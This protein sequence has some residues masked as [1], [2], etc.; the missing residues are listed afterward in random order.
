MCLDRRRVSTSGFGASESLFWLVST[1]VWNSAVFCQRAVG[2]RHLQTERRCILPVA[3]E[4]CLVSKSM[5]MSRS[6]HL[7]ETCRRRVIRPPALKT[8]CRQFS[9]FL[10]RIRATSF[11]MPKFTS[12]PLAVVPATVRRCPTAPMTS[13][14]STLVLWKAFSNLANQ[15]QRR[16]PSIHVNVFRNRAV[17]KNVVVPAYSHTLS[18]SLAQSQFYPANDCIGGCNAS[19][20]CMDTGFEDEQ[21]YCVLATRKRESVHRQR[22]IEQANSGMCVC[23]NDATKENVGGGGVRELMILTIFIGR[24]KQQQQPM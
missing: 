23:D 12:S 8:F 17:R 21:C 4:L 14:A 3:I 18:S 7:W 2:G 20:I 22:S 19:S 6:C 1:S 15:H 24:W 16:L 9:K 10:T 11:L 13:T 5:S